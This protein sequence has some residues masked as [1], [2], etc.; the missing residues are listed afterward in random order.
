MRPSGLGQQR[1]LSWAG[2]TIDS[3]YVSALSEIEFNF[4]NVLQASPCCG[5]TGVLDEAGGV[6]PL[7][8]ANRACLIS[9][10]CKFFFFLFFSAEMHSVGE[11]SQSQGAVRHVLGD[12]LEGP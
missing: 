6:T 12:R 3:G 5:A 8:E 7:T 1:V 2:R 4:V 10:W 11:R 9:V